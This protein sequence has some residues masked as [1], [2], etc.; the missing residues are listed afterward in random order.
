MHVHAGTCKHG[1]VNLFSTRR[2][3]CG[4]ISS[5]RTGVVHFVCSQETLP[6]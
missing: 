2:Y 3:L 6:H 1:V 4:R 5:R